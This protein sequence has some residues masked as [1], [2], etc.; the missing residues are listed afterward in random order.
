MTA[1]PLPIPSSAGVTGGCVLQAYYF[2]RMTFDRFR[3]KHPSGR[4]FGIV[5]AI[6][7]DEGFVGIFVRCT[8]VFDSWQYKRPVSV[9]SADF[10]PISGM[11]R[12]ALYQVQRFSVLFSHEQASSEH[13]KSPHLGSLRVLFILYELFCSVVCLFFPRTRKFS[14]HLFI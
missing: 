8:C 14:I 6:R 7:V 4:T 3:R 5:F 1:L 9:G 11:V 10:P 2:A 12:Y 13:P